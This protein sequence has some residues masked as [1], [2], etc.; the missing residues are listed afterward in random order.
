MKGQTQ[1]MN[2]ITQSEAAPPRKPSHKTR[3]I[4]IAAGAV[5]VLAIGAT[6]A[7]PQISHATQV[8]EYHELTEQLTTLRG[9]TAEATVTLEA[10]TALTSVQHT[11]AA[12]F[13]ESVKKLGAAAAPTITTA[14]AK[15]LTA[16]AKTAAADLGDAPKLTDDQKADVDAIN[17][18]VKALREADTKAAAAAKKA[19][20]DP[21]ATT[22][23]TSVLL[24]DVDQAREIAFDPADPAPVDQTPDADVTAEVVEA[25][26]ADV[27]DAEAQLE[28]LTAAVDEQTALQ[29]QIQDAVTETRPAL[30][31]AAKDA[32]SR[33]KEV[34]A[35][36]PK[37]GDTSTV[38]GTAR[39]AGEHGANEKV[40]AVQLAAK[41]T[42][43]QDAAVAAQKAH[44]EAV[45]AEE[46]AAAAAAEA[47]AAEAA[48]GGGY[49]GNYSGGGNGGGW[50]P[51]YG[52]GNT[53]GGG[54]G[55]DPN[56]GGGSAGGGGGNAGGGG[57][58][59]S[60]GGGDTGGGSGGGGGGCLPP[61]AGWFP[62]GG[63]ANGCPTYLPPGGDD[64]EGW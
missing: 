11:A 47:A 42:A 59:G 29:Q 64:T 10:A 20:E 43:S 41:L 2:D 52:G 61:P 1:A 56:Y 25:T 58:G 55:W 21:P 32:P 5:A 63:T 36:V 45:A 50:D 12:K 53:G 48:Y 22:A 15:A 19:K 18:A 7:V 26:R 34:V 44:T 28:E 27:V 33:A 57:G 30:V 6:I 13:V 40:T 60:A 4:L 17:G 24:I 23:P 8:S 35:A 51:N 3:N 31:D 14:H 62:T 38:T 49:D 39:T 54:G 16:A 9:D 46:A 37:A